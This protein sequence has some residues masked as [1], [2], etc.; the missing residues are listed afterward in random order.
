MRRMAALPKEIAEHL[1]EIRELCARH[2]V[3]TLTLFGSAA[4]NDFDPDRSDADFLVEF[5]PSNRVLGL[6]GDYFTLIAELEHLLGRKVD[7]VE[8]D[9]IRNPYLKKAI[10]EALVPIYVAA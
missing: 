9:G 4:R 8:P 7:L 6:G 10:Y 2:H 3:K 1:E 5:L